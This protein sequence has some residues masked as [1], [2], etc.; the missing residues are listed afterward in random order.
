MGTPVPPGQDP[1]SGYGPPPFKPSSAEAPKK[2]GKGLLKAGLAMMVIGVVSGALML[3]FGI[4]N[5]PEADAFPR[6]SGEEQPVELTAGDWTVFAEGG[7][8]LPPRQ[9]TDPN[10][11]PVVI[12]NLSATLTYSSRSGRSGE[13]VGS[14]VAPVDGTYLVTTEAGATVAFA[15]NYGSDLAKS[16][17][18]VLA[19]LFLGGGL[20]LVGLVVTIIAAT[21]RR[22]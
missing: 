9:I 7:T 17:S 10:G 6:V 11:E 5:F 13:G 18:G 22:R 2:Q 3:W 12:S 16:V 20:L 15:Q 19:G 4:A 21:K 1:P 8:T 14:I